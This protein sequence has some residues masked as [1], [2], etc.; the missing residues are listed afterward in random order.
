MVTLSQCL[1][2]EGLSP[3]GTSGRRMLE[4]SQA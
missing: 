3:E 1:D 2:E 4:R